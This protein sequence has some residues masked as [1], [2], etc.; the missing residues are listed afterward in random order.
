MPHLDDG[1]PIHLE[2]NWALK[3]QDCETPTLMADSAELYI[4][5]LCFFYPNF[6]DIDENHSVLGDAIFIILTNDVLH[7]GG[8]RQHNQLLQSTTNQNVH[9]LGLL[10]QSTCCL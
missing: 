3:V 9:W 10:S 8:T 4:E 1:V 7:L 5:N 6:F 2:Q